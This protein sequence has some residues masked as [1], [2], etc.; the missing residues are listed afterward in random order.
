M[1]ATAKFNMS[2][3]KGSFKRDRDYEY[4]IDENNRKMVFVKAEEG[5]EEVFHI[6]EFNELFSY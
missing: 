2:F 1:T 3:D 4:R 5:I 6:S